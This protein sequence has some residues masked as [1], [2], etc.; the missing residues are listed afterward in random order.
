MKD[1]VIFTDSGCDLP[2]DLLKEWGVECLDL[3]FRFEGEDDKEYATADI[4]PKAFYDRMR[5]GAVAKTA[6]VNMDT[7][8]NAFEAALKGGKDVLYVGFSSGLSATYHSS[9]LAAGELNE[10][11]PDCR[12]MTVDTL[13][14]SAGQGMLVWLAVD[15]K[16]KGGTIEETAAAVENHKMNLAHWFTV[17]DLE[18]LKRGGRVSPAVAFVGGLLGIKPVLHVDNEG[19]LIKRGTVR[20]RK[21]ALKE[22]V[23]K[24]KELACCPGESPVYICN[25]DCADDVE[26]LKE[27]L[28][29]ACACDVDLVVDI[30][31]IIGAHAGPGTIAVFFLGKER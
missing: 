8:K 9:T 6:A 15:T 25:A 27:L 17:D 26:A 1:F 11:Y 19:H 12:V 30:G 4:A 16:K 13:A 20:G 2:A 31:P 5:E 28:D 10:E 29:D 23:N 7:F 22:L 3:T 14:A 18:Y 24:Y 21:A